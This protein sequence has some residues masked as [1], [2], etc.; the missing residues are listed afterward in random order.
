MRLRLHVRTTRATDR[1]ETPVWQHQK[2]RK[3]HLRRTVPATAEY[4]RRRVPR[5]RVIPLLQPAHIREVAGGWVIQRTSTGIWQKVG[6]RMLS[7]VQMILVTTYRLSDAS[8]SECR[9][10]GI[11]VWGLPE[12]I[13]L[14]CLSAPADV[15]DSSKGYAFSARGF[16][17]WWRTHHRNRLMASDL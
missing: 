17:A 4:T 11:Q 15:F 13:Y 14:V 3:E 1:E 7:P 16:G 10:L 5:Y 9:E 2:E 12:L 6:I 8:K